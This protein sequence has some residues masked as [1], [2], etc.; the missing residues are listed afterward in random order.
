M[1][2]DA[3]K[4]CRRHREGK[5]IWSFAGWNSYKI[6]VGIQELQEGARK[7]KVKQRPCSINVLIIDEISMIKSLQF[8][9]LDCLMRKLTIP[10]R[11]IGGDGRLG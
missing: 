5:T 1:H 9:R 3:Y 7:P 6:E 4:H 2:A 8:D 11:A 10:Q